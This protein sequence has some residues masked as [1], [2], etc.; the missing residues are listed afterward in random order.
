M[1]KRQSTKD[2]KV[3]GKEMEGEE[4]GQRQD[5]ERSE[6]EKKWYWEEEDMGKKR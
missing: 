4:R 3:R 5:R 2:K 1:G 6:G